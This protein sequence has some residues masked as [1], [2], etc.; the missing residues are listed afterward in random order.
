MYRIA[1]A[2]LVTLSTQDFLPFT[3]HGLRL[4]EGDLR[5]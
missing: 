4:F 2:V 1:G 3:V 5:L